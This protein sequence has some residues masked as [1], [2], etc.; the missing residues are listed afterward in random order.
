M[1]KII[2]SLILLLITAISPTNLLAQE[3]SI[4][5]TSEDS[6]QAEITGYKNYDCF[7]NETCTDYILEATSGDRVGEEIIITITPEEK[8]VSEIRDYQVGDKVLV[9]SNTFGDEV[10]YFIADHIRS[11]SIYLLAIVF[12]L[13]VIVVGKIKGVS[14]LLGLS[15]SVLVLFTFVLPSILNG[16]NPLLIGIIGSLAIAIPSIY[17][18]HGFNKNSTIALIGTIT[19]LVIVFGLAVLFTSLMHL[20]GFSSEDAMFL[21]GE[22]FS[23][24]MKGILLASVVFGGIGILD[25]V[26]VSQ[27]SVTKELNELN[28]Q[29]SAKELFKKAMNVGQDHISSM[30]N[31]LFLAYASSSLPLAL[32]L[33]Q[34]D[35]PFREIMNNEIIAEEILRTIVGSIGLVLAVPITTGLAVY[36]MKKR[37]F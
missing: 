19:S 26:T 8:V 17:L 20:T 9:I 10:T 27:V 13:I 37:K 1:K 2:T 29:M 3:E 6:F 11:N 30:V 5:E 28:S 35:V 14:S 16:V 12:I 34:Q 33:R 24:N 4:P 21:Q 36:F 22:G 15:L 7:E 31:T 32:L 25:D 18:S 23:L